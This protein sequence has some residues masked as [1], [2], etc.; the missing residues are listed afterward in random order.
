MISINKSVNSYLVPPVSVEILA[1]NDTLQL[2]SINK[3]IPAPLSESDLKSNKNETIAITL[4]GIK[5]KYI[6]IKAMNNPKLPKWHRGKG[7]KGWLF[8]DEI[9]FY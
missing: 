8:V 6:K 9:F 4:D 3:Y 5:Q 1:G 2:K 7:E